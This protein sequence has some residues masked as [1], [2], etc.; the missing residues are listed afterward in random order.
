MLN[1]LIIN[2][3]QKWEKFSEGTL[4]SSIESFLLDEFKSHSVDVSKVDNTFQVSEELD[5]WRKADL[6]IYLFPVFWMSVP[7]KMKK[8]LEEVLMASGGVLFANDG[9]SSSDP[10][11]TYGSGGLSQSKQFMMIGTMNAPASAFGSDSFFKGDFDHLMN[12]LV[13]NNHFIGIEKQIPSV[14]FNDVVKNPQIEKDFLSL[15]SVL[16]QHVLK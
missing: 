12:W 7:W 13:K 14:V 4:S 3:H 2:G 9:R 1:I 8:Y 15:K 10:S 11:K 5:R 16:Q 6:I